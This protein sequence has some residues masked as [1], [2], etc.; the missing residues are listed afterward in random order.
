M[1]KPGVLIFCLTLKIKWKV[2]SVIVSLLSDES[3][4]LGKA[5]HENIKRNHA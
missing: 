2:A 3:F 1:N 5:R 4:A